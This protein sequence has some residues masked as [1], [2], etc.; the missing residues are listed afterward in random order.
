MNSISKATPARPVPYASIRKATS[1]KTLA[2]ALPAATRLMK[3]GTLALATLTLCAAASQAHD[4]GMAAFKAGIKK[5]LAPRGGRVV[6]V[7]ASNSSDNDKRTADLVCTGVHDE[8]VI[9]EAVNRLG[10]AGRVELRIGTYMV[11]GFTA[12]PDGQ[13]TYAIGIPSYGQPKT[14]VKIEGQ[15]SGHKAVYDTAAPTAGVTIAVSQKCYDSL[16]P[17]KEYSVIACIGNR[18]AHLGIENL[19][20]NLPDNQKNIVGIDGA[21][22]EGIWVER[23]ELQAT[24]KNQYNRTQKPHKGVEGCV[25]VRGCQG[26]NYSFE[27]YMAHICVVGFGTGFAI[28]GEHFYGEYLST[29]FC[30]RGF[31]FN[32][33]KL[34]SGVWVHPITLINCCDEASCHYPLFGENTGRQP[35]YIINFNMEHYP[36]YFAAGGQLATETT[37]GQWYGF[38]DYS[39]MNFEDGNPEFLKNDPKKPFWADGCGMGMKSKND[40]HKQMCGTAERLSYSPNYMQ[41]IWDTDLNRLLVCTD[42]AKKTWLDAM[43]NPADR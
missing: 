37:P 5:S 12:S 33:Y 16:D 14:A 10:V 34:N 26:S 19:A 35:V 39:I 24:E 38:I 4:G 23:C 7:A 40:A 28:G 43:G 22:F 31:T 11:D 18:T 6:V 9:Q 29:V 2:Q 17:Q 42:P 41:Q 1:R 3:R 20:V 25:G 15:Q 13:V 36:N 27:F 30:T 21:R 8:R 32:S